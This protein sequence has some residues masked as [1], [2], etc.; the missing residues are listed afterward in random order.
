MDDYWTLEYPKKWY[1]HTWTENPNTSAAWTLEE[2]QLLQAGIG[3]YGSGSKYA[4]CSVCQVVVAASSNISPEI[5][6]SKSYLKVNYTPESSECSLTKPEQ[7]STN[8]ARNVKMFNFW[9]GEREVYDLNR[10]GKSMVLTGGTVDVGCGEDAWCDDDYAFR[11]KIIID[12]TQVDGDLVDFPTYLDID[13]NGNCLN[14][15]GYD[16]MFCDNT[17]TEYSCEIEDYSDGKLKVWV[18]VP[19]VS[20]TVD[21]E[22]WIYYGKA[23]VIVNPSS[24]DTWD[25]DFLTVQHMD[26]AT[27]STVLDSTSND[28]DGTKQAANQ[29]IETDGKIGKAQDFDGTDY[30][31]FGNDASLALGTQNYSVEFWL[32]GAGSGIAVARYSGWFIN[33]PSG[34][35]VFVWAGA[36]KINNQTSVANVRDGEWHHC[37]W[38]CD[39][40]GFSNIYVDGAASAVPLDISAMSAEDWSWGANLVAGARDTG[41]NAPYTGIVEE[42]RVSKKVRSADWIS[43]EYANQNSPDTFVSYGLQQENHIDYIVACEAILC[44]RDMARIGETITITGLSLDY[45]NGTYKIRQ[46]G[47]N[48]ISE[49]PSHFKWILELEDTE[50]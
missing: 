23:D 11:K 40:A 8:H 21:T 29:P 15:D 16:I 34:V 24:T 22:F 12:H 9:N 43:T 10:S 5:H 30:I 17:C 32:K 1:S 46:F 3:L 14:A 38:T 35:R 2:V 19:S 18:K 42:I 50:L 31:N 27:T 4:A 36:T 20:S 41:L 13:L 33:I 37:V 47:W 6:T 7:I 28:N 26:D 25:D 45:F 49:K 48:E 39:R 44:I